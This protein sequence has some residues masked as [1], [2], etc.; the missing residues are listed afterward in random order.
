MFWMKNRQLY[1][2]FGAIKWFWANVFFCDVAHQSDNH[3]Q[4]YLFSQIWQYSKYESQKICV[5]LIS[6][7][8][9]P[10]VWGYS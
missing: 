7:V 1:A 9:C 10:N 5:R 3:P 6:V 2:D 8:Q 4:D